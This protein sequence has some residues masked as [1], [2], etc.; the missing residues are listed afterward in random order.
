VTPDLKYMPDAIDAMPQVRHSPAMR[1]TEAIRWLGI[2]T[3]NRSAQLRRCLISY[4]RHLRKFER[5]YEVAIVDDTENPAERRITREWLREFQR[6]RRI[7]ISYAGR[8]EKQAFIQKLA[9]AGI[10]PEDLSFALAPSSHLIESPGANR[11]ALLL[12]TAGSLALSCD[13][14]SICR[15]RALSHGQMPNGVSSY[16]NADIEVQFAHDR[17]SALQCFP[18]AEFDLMSAHETLLGRDL[19]EFI[20]PNRANLGSQAKFIGASTVTDLVYRRGRVGVTL[21]GILGDPGMPDLMGFMLAR[22]DIRRRFLDYWS[23]RGKLD[24][25][26]VVSGVRHPIVSLK[27][28]IMTTTATGIDH[29][30]ILPPFVPGGRGEDT[31]FGLLLNKCN[32]ELYTG[33]VPAAL[34][35]ARKDAALHRR[36]TYSLRLGD[37]LA[38]IV[39][40]SAETIV[41]SPARRMELLASHLLECAQAPAADFARYLHTS[42]LRRIVGQI[43]NCRRLLREFNS[44]PAA[45]ASEL[46]PW[47]ADMESR[48]DDASIG[49]PT[50]A[51]E[52][53]AWTFEGIQAIVGKLGRLLRLWPQIH[54]ETLALQASGIRI[55]APV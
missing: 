14:D 33:F 10:P 46:L 29:R 55:A 41:P 22:G 31:L 52:L 11:N 2:V 21:T 1:S 16:G 49:L 27:S 45:W 26:N 51:T 54:S 18:A 24:A 37:I 36:L 44:E 23:S 6:R 15:L 5:E 3:R 48:L 34:L 35:H 9:F 38:A 28:S 20:S 53:R 13:D 8:E 7:R 39:T 42:A 43:E 47:L 17:L 40:G 25:I 50:D 19:E 12:Q 30:T 4:A 32:P